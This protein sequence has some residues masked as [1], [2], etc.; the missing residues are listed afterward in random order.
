MKNEIDLLKIYCNY[1]FAIEERKEYGEKYG[2]TEELIRMY[3]N[4]LKKENIMIKKLSKK[5]TTNK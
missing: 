5:N 4:Y 3:E 2:D 1:L